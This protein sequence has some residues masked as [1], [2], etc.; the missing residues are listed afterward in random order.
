MPEQQLMTLVLAAFGLGM[1]AGMLLFSAV[2]RFFGWSLNQIARF[3]YIRV[4][5][6]SAPKVHKL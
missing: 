1:L 6:K 4:H 2:K 3:R 5:R